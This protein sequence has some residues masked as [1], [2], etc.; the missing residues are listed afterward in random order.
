MKKSISVILSALIISLFLLSSC[1]SDISTSSDSLY[2]S[3][4]SSDTSYNTTYSE[5][6]SNTSSADILPAHTDTSSDYTT[7]SNSTSSECKQT[8]NSADHSRNTAKASNKDKKS[9]IVYITKTGDKYHC[10]GC[11][12]LKR[13]KIKISLKEAKAA[14]YTPCS[15]CCPPQ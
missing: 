1:S 10:S 8:T 13:S 15:V 11:R 9:T 12:Y 2:D 7:V 3:A 5:V 4:Y 6:S 14:G